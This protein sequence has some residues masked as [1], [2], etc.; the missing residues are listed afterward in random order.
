M[1]TGIVRDRKGGIPRK[2]CFRGRQKTQRRDRK[3]RGQSMNER[4]FENNIYLHGDEASPHK[5]RYISSSSSSS[6]GGQGA[7]AWSWTSRVWLSCRSNVIVSI[8]TMTATT[9]TMTT[10]TTIPHF[11]MD[12]SGTAKTYG[13][14]RAPMSLT[15]GMAPAMKGISKWNVEKHQCGWPLRFHTD[16]HISRQWRGRYSIYR[17]TG[18]RPRHWRDI[19]NDIND[20]GPKLFY[21]YI[22]LSIMTSLNFVR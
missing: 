8:E 19:Y 15:W 22:Y 14:V 17:E 11:F 9:T 13:N 2:K 18:Y 21:I 3:Q 20:A 1:A 4:I 12:V 16:V 5:A 6:K 10:T 7:A